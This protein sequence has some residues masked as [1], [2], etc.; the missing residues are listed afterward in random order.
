MPLS[1]FHSAQRDSFSGGSK[2]LKVYEASKVQC[3]LCGVEVSLKKLERHRNLR[4]RACGHHHRYRHCNGHRHRHRNYKTVLCQFW[5]N[6]NGRCQYGAGCHFAHG[7]RELKRQKEVNCVQQMQQQRSKKE[8]RV[9]GGT[10]LKSEE[11]RRPS[12]PTSLPREHHSDSDSTVQSTVSCDETFKRHTF[13]T[14]QK[15]VWTI[16]EF[17]FTGEQSKC[18]FSWREQQQ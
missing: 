6:T 4:C 13:R 11:R 8:G 12:I 3:N 7:E 2:N 10:A 1:F 18:W 14:D 17:L 16:I 15:K 5:K 9:A